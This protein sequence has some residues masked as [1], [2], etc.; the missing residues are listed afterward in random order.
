M[1]GT[2]NKGKASAPARKRSARKLGK[3]APPIDDNAG[4]TDKKGAA[5]RNGTSLDW[6]GKTPDQ[7]AKNLYEVLE[8]A[9]VASEDDLLW[10]NTEDE[11]ASWLAQQIKQSHPQSFPSLDFDYSKAFLA[12]LYQIYGKPDAPYSSTSCPSMAQWVPE[13]QKMALVEC[14]A[15]GS[16]KVVR[17][18]CIPFLVLALV[19]VQGLC[20]LSL[21]VPS[22]KR[23]GRIVRPKNR[24]GAFGLA[25]T[26]AQ[27]LGWLPTPDGERWQTT[28][29]SRT[30]PL[31]LFRHV[32]LTELGLAG[33]NPTYHRKSFMGRACRLGLRLPFYV[34]I[35]S[36][37]VFMFLSRSLPAVYQQDADCFFGRMAAGLRPLW[38][39]TNAL[40]EGEGTV[41]HDFL[42]W[43]YE[44]GADLVS[45]VRRM[46]PG[47]LARIRIRPR[48][49]RTL[50]YFWEGLS[51][52][53]LEQDF[54]R[55]YDAARREMDG[56]GT[57]FAAARLR[58]W[59]LEGKKKAEQD[60]EAI[61]GAPFDFSVR[62][63]VDGAWQWIR[64]GRKLDGDEYE[65]ATVRVLNDANEL[66][67]QGEKFNV[68]D[69]AGPHYASWPG[70][71]GLR[72][73]C[74]G[75][76]K[77]ADASYY[78][79]YVFIVPAVI[80]A[81]WLHRDS[82]FERTV[83]E[84]EGEAKAA[85]VAGLAAGRA[86]LEINGQP[87]V[88]EGR[89]AGGHSGRTGTSKGV[90]SVK[91]LFAGIAA[92]LVQGCKDLAAAAARAS[93]YDTL[94]TRARNDHVRICAPMFARVRATHPL[95]R[96][97]EL[98]AVEFDAY[99]L[100]ALRRR[101]DSFDEPTKARARAEIRRIERSCRDDGEDGSSR[102]PRVGMPQP[103]S[104]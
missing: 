9:L 63:Y 65:L 75:L 37:M 34:M 1:A 35:Y 78:L 92:G 24:E 86:V 22:F 49:G 61:F 12:K 46:K 89:C 100:I 91:A 50:V 4:H 44:S 16:A 45:V 47:G 6:W 13:F 64:G 84:A 87:A 48:L 76:R 20:F 70:D 40:F 55:I 14:A 74:L 54:F 69:H 85:R 36:L 53:A 90:A 19:A 62:A 10:F 11:K 31:F 52:E 95:E 93:N 94:V 99:L 104:F 21:H 102:L 38:M 8:D 80:V 18:G 98:G 58:L 30:A 2:K 25:S 101:V 97:V 83:A 39:A 77:Y 66:R 56:I 27:C 33:D 42:R 26:V 29:T 5:R 51:R 79:F 3:P 43:T 41:G 7:P 59:S 88:S 67:L 15:V 32:L 81:V 57:T 68:E 23:A 82:D 103:M 60:D 71:Q 96:A 28:T 73:R 72:A 17:Y